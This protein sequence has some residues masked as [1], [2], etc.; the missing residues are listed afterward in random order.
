MKISFKKNMVCICCIF[1]STFADAQKQ[2][3][4]IQQSITTALQNNPSIKS[5]GLQIEQQRILGNTY[6]D[7]G[8]TNIGL[9][10]GQSNS[11][12]NDTYFSIEQPIPNPSLF[13][14]QKAYYNERIK[15][16]QLN[17]AV[18]KNEL[19]YQVKTIYFQ[20]AYFEALQKLLQ[21]QDT[22]FA[23]F[24]RASSLRFQTGESNLLEKTT[25]ETQL[26]EIRNRIQQNEADILIARKQL[27][28]YLNAPLPV[29]ISI[30]TLSKMSITPRF[31]DSGQTNN[32]EIAF[33]KQQIN[34][35][36]KAIGIEKARGKPD[37]SISYF[38]QSIIGTQE[39]NGQVKSF[40]AGHRFQ[41]VAVGMSIP[42]FYKPYA[43]RVKA[44]TVDK[45]IA[46]TQYHLFS[47]NQQSQYQQAFQEYAK[48]L[49]SVE[50]YETSALAN[51]NLILRQAQIAFKNGEIGYVEFL[52]AL[53]TYRDIKSEYLNAI[54]N[55][56][57][58]I[59]RIQYLS[60]INQ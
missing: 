23:E 41:G 38:N 60:G 29:N 26:N 44:A 15:G 28:T 1:I 22:L 52:Q 17:L 30:D 10:Y 13:K 31:I 55:L 49:R 35:A 18:S 6:R 57:Q 54:N 43:N 40:G 33:I 9:Q 21:G 5:S 58:S 53:R 34:I 45:K 24:A 51:G 47:I 20:L 4:T 36:D 7:F 27:E 56:N 16:S 25:A 2:P 50:Y 19:V 46:E 14:N 37:F 32:P 12:R 48:N 39:V 11:I 59:I 42:I 3:F 8:K